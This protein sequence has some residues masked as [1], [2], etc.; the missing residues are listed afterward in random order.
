MDFPSKNPFLESD[1]ISE[2]MKQA[3]NQCD[4]YSMYME[5]ILR[6]KKNLPEIKLLI[7]LYEDT[8]KEI[9]LEKFIHFCKENELLDILLVGL[10]NDNCKNQ[11]IQSGLKVSCYVQFHLP[12]EEVESAMES[13]GFVYL[14]AKPY[15]HQTLHKEYSTL[16]DCIHYLRQSGIH[17][18]IY[19]GVGVHRPEDAA[20]VREAGADAAFVGSAILKLQN[21]IPTMKKTIQKFLSA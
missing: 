8:L 7:L 10:K 3:L 21:D 6:I 12:K 18:P 14:Q 4:D 2:R 17:R 19:C 16:K 11:L 5:S 20:M 15:P 1:Y 13:N 9:G